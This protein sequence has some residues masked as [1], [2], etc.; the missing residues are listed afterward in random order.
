MN[1]YEAFGA[2]RLQGLDGVTVESVAEN[3]EGGFAS[4]LS[5]AAS[6]LPGSL[7]EGLRAALAIVAVAALCAVADSVVEGAPARYVQLAGVLAIAA[8][9]VTGLNSLMGA[10]RDAIG[11][12][13][14]YSKALLPAMAAASAASGQPASALFRHAGTLLASDL[15]ITLYDRLLYPL[16]YVYAALVTFNAA[17][18]HD[19]VKRI[20]GLVKWAVGGALTVSLVLFTAY[21]TIGG[22]ISGSADAVSVKAAK[23][24]LGGFVPVVGGIISD[25]SETLLLG[26]AVI[27]NAVGIFGLLAVLGIALGPCVALAARC[28][29]VK[30]GAALAGTL[31]GEGLALYI[32]SLAGLYSM[33]LGLV[34]ASAFLLII[35]IVS[36]IMAG[37]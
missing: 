24:A 29:C 12:M 15:L 35:S 36:A 23:T 27:K 32:D 20:A 22:A 26:A 11:Q 10:G 30:L 5:Q 4:L 7:G 28:L 14:A 17:L 21:L 33:M 6:L 1:L 16:L 8:L 13:N 31:G 2:D 37:G 18:P 25:A 19:M 34:S 9:T 3:W